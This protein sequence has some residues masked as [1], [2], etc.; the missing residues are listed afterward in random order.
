MHL[1]NG[2]NASTLV[3]VGL[4]SPLTVQSDLFELNNKQIE[5]LG[6]MQ[7]TKLQSV[8]VNWFS[9]LPEAGGG[10]RFLMSYPTLPVLGSCP[11]RG[12]ARFYLPHGI[13]I[14]TDLVS[15]CLSLCL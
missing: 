6:S 5:L 12:L 13:S 10:A 11:C 1:W 8:H 3:S 7:S 9:C 14:A 15:C 2:Q 4:N